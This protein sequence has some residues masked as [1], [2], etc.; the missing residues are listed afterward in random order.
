MRKIISVTIALLI[1]GCA[2]QPPKV[3]YKAGT[4]QE[5]FNRDKMSC[6]QYG[7]QSAQS[8]GLGNNM[9]VDKWINDEATKCM[10]QLGYQ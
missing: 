1:L 3:W 4:T 7:M 2:T 5:Q 8:H 9:F 6:Q 10:E